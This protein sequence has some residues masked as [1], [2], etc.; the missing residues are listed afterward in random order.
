MRNTISTYFQ[1]LQDQICTA[2]EKTDGKGK[3]HEDLWQHHG[4]G[5]GRTRLIQ[6]GNILEKGGSI[7]LPCRVKPPRL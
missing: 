5:G 4:G 6:S 7:F 2:I 1:H 3:F